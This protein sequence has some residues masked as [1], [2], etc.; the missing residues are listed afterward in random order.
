MC[1]EF[2]EAKSDMVGNGAK[3][4]CVIKLEVGIWFLGAAQVINSVQ[5]VWGYVMALCYTAYLNTTD[6][7][8]DLLWYNI[9][10]VVCQIPMFLGAIQYGKYF[11]HGNRGGLHRAHFYNILTLIMIYVWTTHVAVKL[12]GSAQVFPGF[13]A[14]APVSKGLSTGGKVAEKNFTTTVIMCALQAYWY[15]Q[16]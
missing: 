5:T 12:I 9:G 6:I 4:C 3:C 1:D 14:Q 2:S 16:A 7:K 10:F 13:Q 15:T 8:G 11:V